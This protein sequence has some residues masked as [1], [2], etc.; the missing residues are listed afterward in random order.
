MIL[1]PLDGVTGS[2][3]LPL[4]LFDTKAT[5]VFTELSD[6]VIGPPESPWNGE[7]LLLLSLYRPLIQ[8]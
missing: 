7:E 6:T 8:S 1:V 3:H 2:A 4:G 5:R